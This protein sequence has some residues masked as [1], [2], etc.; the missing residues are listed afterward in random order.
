MRKGT[1]ID[2]MIRLDLLSPML[3]TRKMV[4][5]MLA[6]GSGH[7]VNVASLAGKVGTAYMVSYATAKAGLI[8][9]T[10][11]LRAELRDTGVRASVIVPGIVAGEGMFG[12]R[13]AS[14]A[15][16]VSRMLGTSR[17]EQ[18]AAAVL[19]A[20]LTEKAEIAVSPAPVRLLSALQQLSPDAVDWLQRKSGVPQMLRGLAEAERDRAQPAR[21]EAQPAARL[22]IK[23]ASAPPR[24]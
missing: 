16:R 12:R 23:H 21:P 18:V 15:L 9:F 3:L 17:P 10:H 13:Q 8:A 2:Q 4:T 11:A 20:L 24:V 22:A 7:V 19:A 14:H 6:N 1:L 5:R